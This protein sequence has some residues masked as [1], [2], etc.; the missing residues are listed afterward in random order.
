MLATMMG[1]NHVD[2]VDGLGNPAVVLKV[3]PTVVYLDSS[4]S[5]S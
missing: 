2:M 5:L 3:F 4:L 1:C